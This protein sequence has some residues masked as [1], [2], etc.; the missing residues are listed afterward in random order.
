MPKIDLCFQGWFR[1]VEIT[2]ASDLS[3]FQTV[4]VV[5]M[6]AK[7]L[8]EALKAGKLAIGLD[9]CLEADTEDSSIELFDYDVPG[10]VVDLPFGGRHAPTCPYHHGGECLCWRSDPEKNPELDAECPLGIVPTCPHAR[11]GDCFS[12]SDENP[13]K[14]PDEN[15]EKTE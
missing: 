10:E 15:P 7:E 9:D 13:E 8:V 4:S 1:G 3:T 11:E 6:D 14:K 5:N 2:E 12:D